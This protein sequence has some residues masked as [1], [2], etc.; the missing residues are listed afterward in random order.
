[1]EVMP[2]HSSTEWHVWS[3]ENPPASS[4]DSPT[5]FLN[6]TAPSA[7]PAVSS[8]HRRCPR[9]NRRH[10]HRNHWHD[11]EIIYRF[12]CQMTDEAA[13]GTMQ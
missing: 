13:P 4:P 7:Q 3:M 2:I 1:M 10:P 8:S 5:P 11:E 9:R 12:E 6:S